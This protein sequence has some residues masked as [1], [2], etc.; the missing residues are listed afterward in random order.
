M[1]SSPAAVP[2]S[3]KS[4][5][6]RWGLATAATLATALLAWRFGGA[7]PAVGAELV[8]KLTPVDA[9]LVNY[10]VSP[11]HPRILLANDPGLARLKTQL[12]GNEAA[13]RRFRDIV[14]SQMSGGDNYG[15]EPWYAA[16][17]FR[18]TGEPAYATYAVAQTD[19]AV[20][21]EEMLIAQDMRANVGGDSYLEVGRIVGNVEI[22]R[23]HV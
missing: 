10:Q 8:S 7:V 19:A 3:A 11:T 14:I 23:A 16:L 6:R 2:S 22:G 4:K 12:Q 20:A 13:A 21:A 15:F 5:L 9:R 18:L 1:K 17:M